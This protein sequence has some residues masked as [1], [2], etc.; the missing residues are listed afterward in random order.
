MSLFEKIIG[1]IVLVALLL[2]LILWCI[3]L[4]KKIVGILF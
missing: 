2:T 1:Y 3:I 4:F